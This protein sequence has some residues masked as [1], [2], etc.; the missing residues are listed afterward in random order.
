MKRLCTPRFLRSSFSQINFI[1]VFW[2]SRKKCWVN[3]PWVNGNTQSELDGASQN[4]L[5]QVGI[6]WGKSDP[7]GANR[8]GMEEDQTVWGKS[9]WAGASQNGVKQV[10][11]DWGKSKWV[12]QVKMGLSKSETVGASWNGVEQVR[13]SWGKSEWDGASQNHL[14]QVG[15]GWSK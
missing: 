12:E 14:R 5:G 4:W 15:M 6:G 3:M 13:T 7:V 2:E 8:N 9:E 10:R 11:I 1:L